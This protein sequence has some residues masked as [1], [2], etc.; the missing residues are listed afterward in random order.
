LAQLRAAQDGSPSQSTASPAKPAGSEEGGR[1]VKDHSGASSKQ[2]N[3]LLS[4]L[5]K[6]PSSPSS[7]GNTSVRRQ[8]IEPF[9]PVSTLP[10]SSPKTSTPTDESQRADIRELS[11]TKALPIISTL[12]SDD[13]FKSEVRRMKVDQDTLERRLWAKMEKVKG[14]HEKGTRTDREMYVSLCYLHLVQPRP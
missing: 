9:G 11:F 6:T 3:D 13:G 14:D 2:L 8:L 7:E 10:S 12:L 1:T 5:N 4:S